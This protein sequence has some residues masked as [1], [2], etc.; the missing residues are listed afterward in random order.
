MAKNKSLE[1]L[2]DDL[3]FIGNNFNYLLEQKF[4]DIVAELFVE[5]GKATA[6]D[7]GVARGLIKKILGDLNRPDLEMELEHEIYEYWKTVEQR[8]QEGAKCTLVKIKGR[9]K[10]II[11]DDGFYNQNEGKVSAY[12]PRND[13]RIMPRQVDFGMDLL[14]NGASVRIEKAFQ[15][16]EATIILLLEKGL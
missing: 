1:S 2:I 10:I 6:Y 11:E 12:H 15:K 3:D 14:E 9:Y 13:T 16:L 8:K 5:I 4:N 7:T